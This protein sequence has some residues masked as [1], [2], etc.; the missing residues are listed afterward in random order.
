MMKILD[1]KTGNA[2]TQVE[3]LLWRFIYKLQIK[4]SI[5]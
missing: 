1:Y 4:G 5:Y 3:D 2:P